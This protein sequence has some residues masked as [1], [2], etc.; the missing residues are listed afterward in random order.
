MARLRPSNLKCV[1]AVIRYKIVVNIFHYSQGDRGD[2]APRTEDDGGR[3][4]SNRWW[5]RERG[6]GGIKRGVRYGLP[7]FGP[8]L[9]WRWKLESVS[10]RGEREKEK[11]QRNYLEGMK[12]PSKRRKE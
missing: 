6:G 3:H 12:V 5:G 2:R 1:S 8:I 7:L 4:G 10:T 9:S 11:V